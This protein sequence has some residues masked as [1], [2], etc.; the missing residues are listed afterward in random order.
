MKQC[1]MCAQSVNEQQDFYHWLKCDTLLCGECLSKLQ[2]LRKTYELNGMRLHA[3]YEYN[4]F[5][6]T[7][8]FQYKESLDVELRS[9]F[10]HED[11][12][13]IEKRYKGF[14]M[15]LMPSSKEKTQ[16]RGFHALKEMTASLKLK[17][18]QPFYKN[19]NHKQSALT[20][21][22]RQNIGEILRMDQTIALPKRRLLLFDDV[23]TSGAT[24]SA[25]YRLLTQHQHTNA[26]ALVLCLHP[27]F[28]ETHKSHH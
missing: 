10:I 26:E 13:Y 19:K 17:K 22:Q 1:L 25:A 4:E 9:C 7:M 18:L 27:R 21:E 2:P 6:E 24:L 23:C 20:Y 15:L 16:E 14:T 8:L 28:I 5:I 11:K 3:L 12:R